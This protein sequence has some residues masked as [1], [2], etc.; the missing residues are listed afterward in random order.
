MLN[1]G[2]HAPWGPIMQDLPSPRVL[3]AVILF[4]PKAHEHRLP[5]MTQSTTDAPHDCMSH[6]AQ[7]TPTLPIKLTNVQELGQ[8]QAGLRP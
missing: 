1:I 4:L 8:P 7:V 6:S 5:Q 2:L 3:E